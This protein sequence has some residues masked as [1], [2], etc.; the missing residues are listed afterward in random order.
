MVPV[1]SDKMGALPGMPAMTRSALMLR[2][3]GVLAFLLATRAGAADPGFSALDA[4]GA[5]WDRRPPVFTPAERAALPAADRQRLELTLARIGAPGAP[6]LLPPELEHPTVPV[7][8]AMAAEARTPQ[9]RVTALAF[10]NRLKA[11]TALAALA[12]LQA[13]DARTWP[14]HLH[15]EGLVA[16]ARLNGATLTPELQ[17]FLDALQGAGKNDGVRSASARLRLV[18]AGLQPGTPALPEPIR[19]SALDAWNRGPWDRRAATHLKL[20][21]K[22]FGARLT[23]PGLPQRLLEGLPAEAGPAGVPTALAVLLEPGEVLVRMAALDYLNRLTA[24]DGP[25]REA[26]MKAA[27]ANTDPSLWPGYLALLRR[28][29]GEA[30]DALDARLLAGD[31]PLARSAALEDLPRAPADL[32]PLVKRLW[33]PAE[34]DAVQT[35]LPALERWR[36]PEDARR[37]LLARFLQHPCWTARLDAYRLLV[38]LAPATPWPGAPEPGPAEA[39]LLQEARRLAAAARPVRLRL[40]FDR[41]RQLVLKLDPVNAPIN[42]AN[43]ELLARSGFFDHRRVGRIVPD[44]V[45]QMGSPVDTMDGGPGYTVRCEDSLDWYGPGSVGMALSGKDTGGSQFFITTNA[46]PHLT[47]RYTRVGAV[48]DPDHALPLL[49]NLELGARILKVEVLT[50]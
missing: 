33:T 18:L 28:H 11:P 40:S 45:V 10:L 39:A 2:N 5:E 7:W 3:L 17:G 19:L 4:L 36:L 21:A 14:R 41:N 23:E 25:A 34:Y 9:A 48:E 43:L 16:Q 15:L 37:A 26:V 32:E 13:A 1:A 50:P 27:L 44:F 30:A 35:F 38:K 29:A 12:G 49:D 22:V 47:G 46:T 8:Q 31:D 42:V 24:L 6:A 20:M